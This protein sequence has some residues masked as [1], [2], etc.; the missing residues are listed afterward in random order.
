MANKTKKS[1]QPSA[2]KNDLAAER[3]VLAGDSQARQFRQY[4][5]NVRLASPHTVAGYFQDIAQFLRKN[6]EILPAEGSTD[7]QWDKV[8]EARARHFAMSLA[9][10]G[11]GHSS[12]NRKISSLRS[13]FRYLARSDGK[14]ANPFQDVGALK[15]AHKLPMFLLVEQVEQLLAAPA[16]YW[17]RQP[18]PKR[19]DAIDYRDF[20]AAR[21][22]A[23]LEVIY[24]GGLRISEA[25]S[26]DFQDID[27]LSGVFKV[28]GKGKKERFC[29]L[30]KPAAA[31][32]QRY[33]RER[34]KLGLGTRR[35]A[36]PLFR[37][38][39]GGR[40][41]PRSVERNFQLYI[42][43]AN[44]PSDCTPHKLRHSFA[45]H[46]LSAGA[47]LRTVQELLGHANLSTTQIYTHV[48]IKRL[49]EVY[50][51]AHPKA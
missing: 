15:A 6:P 50:K 20:E 37:N 26:L 8:T 13:F 41:T 22:T 11:L 23:V 10:D 1:E 30:G 39:K 19:E 5:A 25:T 33:L 36:G 38:V 32:L 7:C 21:D 31:A 29:V 34:E 48:N 28:R 2:V 42:Q 27:F 40:L 49:Q 51:K 47:D 14:A 3:E 4:L 46:M 24:S 18:A 44:L 9:E 45:T 12:V 35:E 16:I 43:E 17:A